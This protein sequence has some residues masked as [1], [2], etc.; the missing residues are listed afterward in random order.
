M[1]AHPR[2]SAGEEPVLRRPVAPM[3]AA[4]VDVVPDGPGLVHEPKWDW[5]RA[6]A[7]RDRAGVYL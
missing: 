2:G 7:F 4:P 3:L 5:W 6:I 1:P